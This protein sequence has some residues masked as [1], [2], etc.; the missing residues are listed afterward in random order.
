MTSV[1]GPAGAALRVVCWGTRGS[2]PSPGPE[3]VHFGG[4]TPCVEVRA[5]SGARIVLDAGTGIWRLGV[6]L[7]REGEPLDADLFL[8]HFHWDHVQ[9]FPFF[10]PLYDA[11]TVLR[12]HAPDQPAATGEALLRGLMAPGYF[13][14]PFGALRAD[15]GFRGVDEA[16]PYTRLGVEVAAFRVQHDG[17]A[18]GYRVRAGG[19]A[20]AY[21]PDNELAASGGPLFRGPGWY[22]ALVRFLEGADLLL[23]DATFTE[24]EYGSPLNRGGHSTHRQALRLAEDAGAR[25]LYFFHH[26]PHRSDAELA[27]L[28]AEFRSGARVEVGIARE[29]EELRAPTLVPSP[30]EVPEG[31]R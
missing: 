15:L 19:A 8:T 16:A 1:P 31:E 22:A 3:T 18:Y 13:P 24:A 27:G 26:A 20:V 14:I 6:H 23:H 30:E 11:R 10:H 9:G 4:N 28:A 12:I 5:A 29:G 7:R 21:I 17:H 2:I 25:R